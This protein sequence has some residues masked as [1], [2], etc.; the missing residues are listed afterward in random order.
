MQPKVLLLCANHNDLGVI[1]SLRRLGYY[2]IVSGNLAGQIGEK[3]ADQYI[4]CDYSDQEKMLAIAR[5]EKVS[6]VF[7]CCNDYG[8]YTAAYIAEK[9]GFTGYDSCETTRLLHNKDRFKAFAV[10]NGLSVV[11][12]YGFSDPAAALEY[13]RTAVYPQI[14]KPID[15]FGGRGISKLESFQDAETAIARA[16]DQSREK[17]IVIERYIRGTQH[18]FCSFLRDRKVIAFC[19]NNEYSIQDAYRVEIDTWP[20]DHQ[21]ELSPILIGQIE[22]IADLLQLKDGIFHLQYILENGKPYIIEVMRRILGNMY[23]IPAEMVSGFNFDYW[24]T[25][26]L[27]GLSCADAPTAMRSEGHFAYKMLLAPRNGVIRNIQVPKG[28][29]K[30]VWRQFLIKQPGEE[31]THFKTEP[32][33]FYFLMFSNPAE[34]KRVLIDEYNDS[35]VCMEPE[36]PAEPCRETSALHRK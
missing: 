8:V 1:W 17:R 35:C 32:V 12:S 30:Y 9:M 28:Y 22:K 29:E 11:K 14:V 6:A 13:C 5:R 10:E 2:I 16:F 18:G 36:G 15:A 20:A 19:S 33:G 21:D 3:F 7:P 24:E 4:A 25:R 27:C 23:G 26:A 31:I 34:M